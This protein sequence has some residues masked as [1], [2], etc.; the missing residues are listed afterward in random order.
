MKSF[1]WMITVKNPEPVIN[2]I[3][4]SDD[5]TFIS[6]FNNNI[7][8]QTKTKDTIANLNNVLSGEEIYKISK[9]SNLIE[10]F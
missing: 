3:N 9:E 6:S 8:I 10:Y 5:F 7:L 2:K 1:K 4:E